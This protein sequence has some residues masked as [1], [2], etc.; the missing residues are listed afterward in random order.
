MAES[1][2]DSHFVG[3]D[4]SPRQIREA[5]T[6]RDILGLQ[7]VEFR[8]QNILAVEEQL[9]SFDYII[10]HG[11]YSWVSPEVQTG[12]LRVCQS[13]LA[14]EGIAYLSYNTYPGWHYR[15]VVRD[16]L[17]FHVEAGR[18]AH[19]T[20][21]Q[22]RQLLELVARDIPGQQDPRSQLITKECKLLARQADGYIFHEQ[23]EVENR[24]CYFHEFAASAA[25]YGLQYVAEARMEPLL[26]SIPSSAHQAFGSAATPDRI[27]YEQYLDFL[28]HRTFRRTLLCHD[29]R[30]V[31]ASP[32]TDRLRLCYF[33]GI[34]SP[35]SEPTD[36]GSSD[37][38]TFRTTDEVTF[39]SQHPVVKTTLVAVLELGPLAVPFDELATQIAAR[40]GDNSDQDLQPMLLDVLKACYQRDVVRV[41]LKA[42]EFVPHV[43]EHP[44]ASPVARLQAQGD[45]RVTNREHRSIDLSPPDRFLLAHLD[46]SHGRDELAGVLLAAIGSGKLKVEGGTAADAKPAVEN[47]RRLVDKRAAYLADNGFLIG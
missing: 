45:S 13:R 24:P 25:S 22:A 2:P 18:S 34:A 44:V 29:G 38:L 20:V 19:S 40:M 32:Q 37:P 26:M 35:T 7:N 39:T 28:V 43:T 4:L 16:M 23:L 12:I 15:G 33:K 27:R 31:H 42:P 41:Y 1:L 17:Q 46:G 5:C 36:I 6:G 47:L 9:G 3:I 11:V 14:P 30:D 21:E 8:E 10:G